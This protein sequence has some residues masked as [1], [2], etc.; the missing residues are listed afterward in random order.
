V[1]GGS[2]AGGAEKTSAYAR[3]LIAVD[4]SGPAKRAVEH[5]LDL[6]QVAGAAVL[7]LHVQPVIRDGDGDGQDVELERRR[8]VTRLLA[9]GRS[10]FRRSGIAVDTEIRTAGVLGV[11]QAIA[12]V[13]VEWEADVIVLGAQGHSAVSGMVPGRTSRQVRRLARQPV[14]VV[15]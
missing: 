4:A 10:T 9:K 13:A 6:A 3:I 7:V 8:Q 14:I 15:P 5:A 12:E 11:A 2:G 1:D